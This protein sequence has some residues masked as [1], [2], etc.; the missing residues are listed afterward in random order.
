V[1]LQQD[2]STDDGQYGGQRDSLGKEHGEFP[3]GLWQDSPGGNTPDGP[4]SPPAMGRGCM[5]GSEEGPASG[6]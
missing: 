4:P 6:S 2:L 3:W 5:R 1:Q